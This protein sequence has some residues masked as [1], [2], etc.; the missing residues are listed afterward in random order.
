MATRSIEEV[1]L[2]ATRRAEPD[3]LQAARELHP[4]HLR[5]VTRHLRHCLDPDGAQA[6]AVRQEQDRYLHLS[7]SLDGVWYVDGR[8]DPEGGA[9]LAAALAAIAGPP[10]RGDGRSA[11]QRRTPWSTWSASAWTRATCPGRAASGRT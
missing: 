1:G 4:P 8:L 7:P 10:G 5:R 6:E 2:E 3:L 11:A 9:R